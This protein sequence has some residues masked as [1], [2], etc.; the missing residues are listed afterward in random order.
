MSKRDHWVC[1]VTYADGSNHL[2]S[3]TIRVSSKLAVTQRNIARL[4]EQKTGDQVRSIFGEM[5]TTARRSKSHALPRRRS[6]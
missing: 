2:Q 6:R 5:C 4:I 3:T 1:Q